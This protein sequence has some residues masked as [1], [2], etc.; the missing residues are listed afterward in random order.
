MTLLLFQIVTYMVLTIVSSVMS[1]GLLVG[2][3]LPL[4]LDS[5]HL[6]HSYSHHIYYGNG[7]Y[8]WTM[9]PKY[10]HHVSIHVAYLCSRW[11]TIYLVALQASIELVFRWQ[12]QRD[13]MDLWPQDL[14][15]IDDHN[16]ALF[17]VTNVY[18]LGR[19]EMSMLMFGSSTTW[20]RS[21]MHPKFDTTG[22]RTHDLQIMT[23]HFMSLRR[24]L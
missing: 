18:T 23:V 15:Y 12:I 14:R 11:T 19:D 17:R 2:C 9:D 24:L 7:T 1:I 5:Y 22:V 13:K 3:L 21:T 6:R 20:D 16:C 8:E 4:L 10:Y